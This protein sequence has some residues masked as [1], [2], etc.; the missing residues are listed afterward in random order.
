MHEITS[1]E[2]MLRW[3]WTQLRKMLEQQLQATDPIGSSLPVWTKAAPVHGISG[4]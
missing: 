1:A 4:G 3:S 2:L